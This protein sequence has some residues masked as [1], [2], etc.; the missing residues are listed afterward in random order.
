MGVVTASMPN[1][2]PSQPANGNSAAPL[3]DLSIRDDQVS[4]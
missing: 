2:E 4:P 3:E 1:G